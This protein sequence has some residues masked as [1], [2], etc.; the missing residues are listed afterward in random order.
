MRVAVCINDMRLL[1]CVCIY[2]TFRLTVCFSTADIHLASFFS[3]HR[4]MSI[5][6]AIPPNSDNDTFSSIFEPKKNQSKSR[7]NDV[8]YT[9]SSAL[10]AME[11]SSSSTSKNVR[12]R[13]SEEEG[14]LRKAVTQASSSNSEPHVLHL[15]EVSPEQLASSI[16]EY[17]K[18]LR[19]F[20]PP[21]TPAP[22]KEKNSTRLVEMLASC[23]THF[24]HELY[25]HF[26]NTDKP[27][28]LRRKAPTPTRLH[29]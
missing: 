16:Q 12:Q 26:V 28:S 29:K 20:N 27:S 1:R 23:E 5:T 9:L 2:V 13:P 7:Q 18:T 14:D 25:S 6:T 22:I 3:V 17:A 21:P 24:I 8:I 19:P 11:S 10:N 15:D 4:P